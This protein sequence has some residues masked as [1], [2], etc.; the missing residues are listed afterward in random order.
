[1]A[2]T[3]KELLGSNFMSKEDR[4]AKKVRYKK[5]EMQ[6]NML[7][8]NQVLFSDR[9]AKKEYMKQIEN[10]KSFQKELEMMRKVYYKKYK[11]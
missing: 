10:D 8:T 9:L 3:I 11:I 2:K 1:M 7:K 6:K 4:K 5:I